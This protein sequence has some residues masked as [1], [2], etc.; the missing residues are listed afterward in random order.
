MRG[1]LERLFDIAVYIV[2]VFFVA[3]LIR[4]AI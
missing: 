2:L 3:N 4:G 1:I